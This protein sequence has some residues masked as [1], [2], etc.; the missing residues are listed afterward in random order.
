M[1]KTNNYKCWPRYGA[2]RSLTDSQWQ[3]RMIQSF[4]KTLENFLL[5]ETYHTIQQS[6]SLIF[7]KM[8]WKLH[9]HKNLHMNVHRSFTHNCQKLEII[10]I[11]LDRWM[12]KQTEAP[13]YHVILFSDKKKL[14]SIVSDI[15]EKEERD[16]EMEHRGFSRKWNHS[17]WSV[18][19]GAQHY[20]FV[21][22]HVIGQPKE[23]AL[24]KKKKKEWALK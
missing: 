22:T 16:E 3:W 8:S 13:P 7:N 4:W 10:K 14:A 18:M 1:Q 20:T 12:N 15:G 21:K 19:V 24:K 6:S 9:P 2:T 23:W 11:F 17:Q 5:S